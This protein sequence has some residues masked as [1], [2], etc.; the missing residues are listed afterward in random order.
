MSLYFGPICLASVWQFFSTDL[1]WPLCRVYLTAVWSSFSSVNL[2]YILMHFPWF[3]HLELISF[4]INWLSFILLWIWIEIVSKPDDSDARF[5]CITKQ[6]L[7]VFFHSFLSTLC[8]SVV[9]KL[10]WKLVNWFYWINMNRFTK[11]RDFKWDLSV[12]LADSAECS[13]SQFDG[14]R[15]NN[16]IFTVSLSL[17]AVLWI[18]LTLFSLILAFCLVY[19]KTYKFCSLIWSVILQ[20]I[21]FAFSTHV[22]WYPVNNW[23]STHVVYTSNWGHVNNI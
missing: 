1:S 21:W 17:K 5:Y 22:T 19:L 18:Y 14:P 11:F 9:Q 2:A 12:L 3:W 4:G 15:K 10:V 23:V 20:P 8:P 13:V 16:C 7:H 6:Y